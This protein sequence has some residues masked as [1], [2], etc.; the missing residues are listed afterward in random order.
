MVGKNTTCHLQQHQRN[1]C[2]LQVCWDG[3][4][5]NQHLYKGV[6]PI[7]AVSRAANRGQDA[8]KGSRHFWGLVK[9]SSGVLGPMSSTASNQEMA[10]PLHMCSW[11]MV[12]G[13]RAKTGRGQGHFWTVSLD[14]GHSTG[15]SAYGS[16]LPC[17]KAASKDTGWT[18]TCT[19]LARRIFTCSISITDTGIAV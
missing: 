19:V 9:R 6:T 17:F 11:S 8:V 10:E 2:W 7:S 18:S 3:S 13:L 12:N 4:L 15:H 16:D 14:H 1:S 5:S